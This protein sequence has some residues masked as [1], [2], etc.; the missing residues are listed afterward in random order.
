MRN[1]PTANIAIGNASREWKRMKRLALMIRNSRDP[2]WAERMSTLFTGIYRQLLTDP[3]E[4]GEEREA[5]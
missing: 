3:P 5:S 1:D 2:V 4:E